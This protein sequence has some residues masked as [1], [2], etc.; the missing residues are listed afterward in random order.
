M[1]QVKKLVRSPKYLRIRERGRKWCYWG[2]SLTNIWELICSTLLNYAHHRY[3]ASLLK[4]TML[5]WEFSSLSVA[6]GWGRNLQLS[7]LYN[8]NSRFWNLLFCL[9]IYSFFV[10]FKRLWHLYIQYWDHV[11]CF[12]SQFSIYGIA[13]YRKFRLVQKEG[14]GSLSLTLYQNP[15]DILS[16]I[17]FP[18]CTLSQCNIPGWA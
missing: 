18:I 7:L 9:K 2:Y 6:K 14:T 12:V 8:W 4:P 5:A 16:G 13:K 15:Q 17:I 10:S 3:V 11:Y 1:N